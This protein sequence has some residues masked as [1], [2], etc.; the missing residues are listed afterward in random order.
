M[1]K[2]LSHSKLVAA[3]EGD[4]STPLPVWLMR[5]AGRYLPE[6]RAVRTKAGSFWALCM[7]PEL[8]AEVTLQ[9]IERFDFDAA[10]VFSDILTIPASMGQAVRVEEGTGP[11]L[12]MFPGSAKLGLPDRAA[13]RPVYETLGIVRAKLPCEKAL[14]GFAGAPWTLATY[15][16][17]E[18]GSPGERLARARV[19]AKNELPALLEVLTSIVTAH[20]AEQVRAGADVVQIFDS[21]AGGLSDEEFATWVIAPTK[22]IVSGLSKAAPKAKV[23][24]FP[25]GVKPAQCAAY[26]RETGVNGVSVDTATSI[27][28][29]VSE[30]ANVTCQGNLDPD[31]LVAGGPVLDRAVESIVA[32]AAGHPFIFNLGHGILPET[33]PPHV[34]HLVAKV[35]GLSAP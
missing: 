30:L 34:Q 6:Y 27:S 26:V 32:A 20:L 18:N 12:A 11:R 13:L 33:P 14:I 8:S 7:N 21:W 35:R 19:Q 17:G 31:V 25:R 5:Q 22:A 28:W 10:I 16:L 9:P 2:A 3:L 24:G 4:K 23:I 15:M 29:A 1:K